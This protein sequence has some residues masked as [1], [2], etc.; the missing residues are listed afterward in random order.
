MSGNPSCGKC[1]GSGM[2]QY[3]D[4]TRMVSMPCYG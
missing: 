4:G 1:S 3:F 2:Y